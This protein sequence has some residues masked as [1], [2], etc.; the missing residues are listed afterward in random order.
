MK[1]LIVQR[2]M[3]KRAKKILNRMRTDRVRESSFS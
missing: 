3:V 2:R 1:E